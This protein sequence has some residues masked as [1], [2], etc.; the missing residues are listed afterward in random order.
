MLRAWDFN[1]EEVYKGVARWQVENAD[2][3]IEDAALWWLGSNEDKWSGWVTAEAAAGVRAALAAG[4]SADGWPARA[5]D[6]SPAERPASYYGG[7]LDIGDRVTAT[8]GVVT[9]G[10]ST[11]GADG[12]WAISIEEGGCGGG[13]VAG[14]TVNFAVNGV[15][16]EQTAQWSAGFVPDDRT[17]GITLTTRTLRVTAFCT[18]AEDA[19]RPTEDE[20]RNNK[21]LFKSHYYLDVWTV[22]EV[23]LDEVLYS[24]NGGDWFPLYELAG[25]R[26]RDRDRFDVDGSN[27]HLNTSVWVQLNALP[28]G[29]HEIAVSEAGVSSDQ[30][31]FCFDATPRVTAVCTYDENEPWPTEEE[32]RAKPVNRVL[33]YWSLR[34][35][36]VVDWDD[37]LYSFNGADGVSDTDVRAQLNALPSGCHEVAITEGEVWSAPFPFCVEAKAL[38]VRAFCTYE[39]NEPWPTLEECRAKPVNRDLDYWSLRLNGVA[40]WDDVLYS[41]NGAAG[42]SE[43]VCGRSSTRFRPAATR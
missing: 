18:F 15:V 7:G 31:R 32:C 19:P 1:V 38:R 12:G 22:G 41:F 17:N 27:W 25:A 34:G 13:A 39:E 33:D 43:R 35:D 5:S 4:E 24:F 16:A 28:H 8:I 42:V 20:C 37:V 6:A 30:Y 10:A 21:T 40:D 23:D 26:Y 29:C 9:C 14:A 36:G 11:A 2:A 3:S